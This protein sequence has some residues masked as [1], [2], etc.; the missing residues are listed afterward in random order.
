MGKTMQRFSYSSR[1]LAI[2]VTLAV[3]AAALMV[4]YGAQA[5]ANGAKTV[6]DKAVLVATRDIPLGTPA[7]EITGGGWV[8]ATRLPAGSIAAGALTSVAQ[9]AHLVAVQPT[10]SGEQ[11]TLRRFG[12]VQQQGLPSELGGS[13]R[14]FELSGSATQLLAGTLQRGNRVDVVGSIRLPESGQTHVAAVVLRNLLVVQAPSGETSSGLSSPQSTL[15]AQLQLTPLQAQ[16]LFW[17]TKNGDW[18]L[19]LRPSGGARD[20]VLQPVTAANLVA[21]TRGR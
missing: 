8:T 11:I 6:S 14:I 4:I 21:G 19:L 17:L 5:R 18:S 3:A 7:S 9:L 13:F 12:R 16:R 10:Y 1:K 15:S 20:L 2:A